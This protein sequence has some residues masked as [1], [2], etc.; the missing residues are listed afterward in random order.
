MTG[1]FSVNYK[2]TIGKHSIDAM[3]LY[4]VYTY[5]YDYISAGRANFTF[6]TLDQIFAG[7][8]STETN[9]GGESQMGRVSYVGRVNYS[10]ANKYLAQLILRADASAKFPPGAQWGYFP[11]VSLGWRI[12]QENFLKNVKNI[13]ELKLRVSYGASGYDGIGNFQYLAGWT[14][15]LMPELWG[16]VPTLGVAPTALA[17]PYLSWERISMYNGGA[18]YSFFQPEIIWV[19]RY[20]LSQVKWDSCDKNNELAIQL[21][22][23]DAV[24]KS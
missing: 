5:N 13:D 2:N 19:V 20:L 21:W 22:R 15:T 18:D 4:E 23:R 6:P 1:Q 7:S 11:S 14:P 8:T 16:G 17:N 24:R 10:Y 3:L 9:N 12:N